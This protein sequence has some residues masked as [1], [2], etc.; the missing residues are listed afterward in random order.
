MKCFVVFLTLLIVIVWL[1]S[2]MVV[3]QQVNF[4]Q[5]LDSSFLNVQDFLFYPNG[6]IFAACGDGSEI[7]IPFRGI[8]RSSDNGQTW[9]NMFAQNV[10]KLALNQKNGDLY[11]ATFHRL[12]RSSDSGITWIELV[13]PPGVRDRDGR[14]WWPIVD[15]VIDS[16]GHLFLGVLKNR[17]GARI[18]TSIDNGNTWLDDFKVYAIR[19]LSDMLFHPDGKVYLG[20]NRG[21]HY[22]LRKSSGD[23]TVFRSLSRPGFRHPRDCFA[24]G[25]NSKGD[26]F[27]LVQGNRLIRY[28]YAVRKFQQIPLP[29]SLSFPTGGRHWYVLHIDPNDNIYVQ[30]VEG[31]EFKIYRTADF[32]VT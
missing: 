19:S 31:E 7:A 4:W 30:M 15:M 26:I 18:Y 8:L 24:L 9:T 20:T 17:I 6:D 11:A 22:S 2:S 10:R 23:K 14:P 25:V 13:T 28:Q 5:Q 16:S 32:G 27:A 29:I 12:F 3:A 21:I 1:G